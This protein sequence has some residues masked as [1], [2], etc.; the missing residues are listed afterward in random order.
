MALKFLS[1][2]GSL[3]STPK[4]S[5]CSHSA[6]PLHVPRASCQCHK[7]LK[8]S[9]PS[10]PPSLLPHPSPSWPLTCHPS[11]HSAHTCV[12]VNP[13]TAHH[14][15]EPSGQP[16]GSASKV[17][18]ESSCFSRPP[19]PPPQYRPPQPPRGWWPQPPSSSTVALPPSPC[20]AG[21]PEC[22]AQ[23]PPAH[24]SRGPLGHWTSEGP[25][26]EAPL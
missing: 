15:P 6:V 16:T 7:H 12:S 18:P 20:S 19:W 9:S 22:G 5:S 4:P 11:G 24:P 14:F 25:G 1:Q 21:R 3:S 10:P 23:N 17:H 13:S 2:L 8:R 26:R